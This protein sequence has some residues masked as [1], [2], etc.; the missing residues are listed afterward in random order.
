MA[1]RR[2]CSRASRPLRIELLSWLV[3]GVLAGR[4]CGCPRRN[5]VDLSTGGDVAGETLAG[6]TDDADAG[7]GTLGTMPAGTAGAFPACGSGGGLG[8]GGS[9]LASGGG[10]R[11]D[12]T[13]GGVNGGD[14]DGETDGETDDAGDSISLASEVGGS[15][16]ERRLAA[17]SLSLAGGGD[18]RWESRGGALAAP[19]Q[20]RQASAVRVGRAGGA[21]GAAEAA[22]RR[23]GLR[24]ACGRGRSILAPPSRGPLLHGTCDAGAVL[25]RVH[26]W[27]PR[28]GPVV[29]DVGLRGR[30]GEGGPMSACRVPRSLPAASV[31]SR[32]EPSW[33]ARWT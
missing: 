19:R 25:G 9:T 2:F 31:A 15:L 3:A 11:G 28:L 33:V 4:G 23:R 10:V 7:V 16:V 30:C 27:H 6:D 29:V 14:E 21:S 12:A 5:G 26:P 1:F 22:G 18:R 24:R 20:A 32:E 8:G 13:G 17:F